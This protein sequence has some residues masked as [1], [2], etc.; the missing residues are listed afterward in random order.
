MFF[1][2]EGC[3]LFSSILQGY[4]WEITTVEGGWGMDGV[5]QS[6][7]PV[8]NGIVNGVDEMEW[9][10]A[11]DKLIARQYNAANLAGNS[12]LWLLS[13]GALY[14]V[15]SYKRIAG[16]VCNSHFWLVFPV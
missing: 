16:R 3:G 14:L 6:R 10:P 11:T 4:A 1:E 2:L 12:W 13:R 15:I 7:Q 8:L 9:D 5:L